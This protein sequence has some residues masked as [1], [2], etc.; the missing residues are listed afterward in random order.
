[1]TYRYRTLETLS[2]SEIHPFLALFVYLAL[3]VT[4]TRARSDE[5]RPEEQRQ[6]LHVFPRPKIYSWVKGSD[7]LV[8]L[9]NY[10]GSRTNRSGDV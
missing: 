2:A 4:C 9:T 5:T 3:K 8:R 10:Q 6:R 1:M 7:P